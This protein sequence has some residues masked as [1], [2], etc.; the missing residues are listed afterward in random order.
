MLS[1]MPVWEVRGCGQA[2]ALL[3]CLVMQRKADQ[4]AIILNQLGQATR[5]C[6]LQMPLQ[7][8]STRVHIHAR[9]KAAVGVVC[10]V[11]CRYL[12]TLCYLDVFLLG[13]VVLKLQLS[14]AR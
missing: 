11:D 10:A 13:T 12:S 1:R 14:Q 5:R 3:S 2:L 4:V 9:L 6:I 8:A 7:Y